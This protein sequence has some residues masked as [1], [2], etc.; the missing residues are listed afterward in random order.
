M[1]NRLPQYALMSEMSSEHASERLP[2]SDIEL[3]IFEFFCDK[4][5]EFFHT[6]HCDSRKVPD[7]EI[8]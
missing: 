6:K 1:K 4:V 8:K 7:T 2:V 3:T 5:I